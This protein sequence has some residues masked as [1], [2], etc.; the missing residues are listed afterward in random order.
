MRGLLA[1][2]VWLALAWAAP[3]EAVII[4]TGDGTGNTS[5]P[6]DD[7]G[8][9]H[10]ATLSWATAVY[11]G[12]GWMLT[13]DHLAPGDVEIGGVLH[14][15]VPGSEVSLA[16]ADLQLFRI[17]S[18][19]GLPP[20]PIATG[21]PAG[22]VVM[23]GQGRN[24]GEATRWLGRDGWQWGPGRALRWGTNQVKSVSVE[25][26]A[27][28]GAIHFT[29]DFSEFGGTTSECQFAGGDSG[30]AVFSESGDV[31]EL[32]GIQVLRT[33]YPGQPAETALFG[34]ESWSAQLSEHRAEILSIVAEPACDNGV[35]EDGDGL[36]D[37][38]D[39]GC[40]GP[41]D[42]FET[43]DSLPCDDGADNDADGRIDFDPA[44][45]ADPGDEYTLPAGEGDP[46]CRDP[47]WMTES[48]KCQDGLDNDGDGAMDYDAGLSRNGVA[49]PAGP[50]EHCVARPYR[51]CEQGE[52]TSC[53]LGAELALLIPV[54]M[55]LRRRQIRIRPS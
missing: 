38:D 54:W 49:D 37:L 47:S 8:W 51:N 13:A 48:P 55:W 17:E 3:A 1:L 15:A 28:S 22:E 7:P 50:D 35:D 40:D 43:S 10:V 11:V 52:C 34:N 16:P 18:D 45:A 24:R 6:L 29:A 4:A 44:T 41:D 14:R 9:G 23:I 27:G 5:A 53:G 20:L 46:G 33:A 25:Y 31:W 26:P 30:G 2:T 36:T 32:A 42:A 21:P 12:D 19:P 39:P